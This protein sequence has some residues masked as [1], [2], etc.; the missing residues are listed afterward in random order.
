MR[1]R[2]GELCGVREPLADLSGDLLGDYTHLDNEEYTRCPNV[3]ST[4]ANPTASIIDHI[5]VSLPIECNITHS[6]LVSTLMAATDQNKPSDHVPIGAHIA[7]T[8]HF[9]TS[10]PTLSHSTLT[11]KLFHKLFSQNLAS[12]PPDPCP[13][14]HLD[15][16]KE[17]IRK[18][19]R[20]AQNIAKRRGARLADERV[21][22]STTAIR[23]AQQNTQKKFI[24]A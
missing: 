24:E 2:T 15:F 1:L 12:C 13:W 20:Q 7:P 11:S 5:Y 22:W 19:V 9:R 17:M 18:T 21:H 8:P 4:K 23:A 14:A 10:V 3:L 16:M 6:I